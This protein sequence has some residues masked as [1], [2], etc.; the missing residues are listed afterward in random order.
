[1]PTTSNVYCRISNTGRPARHPTVPAFFHKVENPDF[2]P[3]GE[4]EKGPVL[5]STPQVWGEL[6]SAK[7]TPRHGPCV[8]ARGRR[9]PFAAPPANSKPSEETACRSTK[10]YSDFCSALDF[11]LSDGCCELCD[12]PGCDNEPRLRRIE[13][14]AVGCVFITSRPSCFLGRP[15]P[16][17][18]CLPVASSRWLL[19]ACVRISRRGLLYKIPRAGRLKQ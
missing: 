4:A 9:L 13:H 12:P 15:Q 6:R 2:A 14:V 3:T 11:L 8:C 7:P 17:G 19:C 10:E 5:R 1:M 18:A 16:P